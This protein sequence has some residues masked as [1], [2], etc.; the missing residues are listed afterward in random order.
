M[1]VDWSGVYP[2]LMTEFKDDESLDLHATATHIEACLSAGVDGFVILG[3][4]GENCSLTPEEKRAV[5][6]CAVETVSGRVPVIAGCAEYTPREAIAYLADCAKLGA[7]GAMVLPAMVYKTAPQETLAH[8]RTIARA[9]DLPIMVYN[10]PISYG[11]DVTPE[12]F[13]ELADEPALVAIKESSDDVRRLTDIVNLVGDRYVLFCG[14]DD[15][16]L[17]AVVLGAVGWVAGLVNAFPHETVELYRHVKAGRLDEA[18]ALYRWFMPLL[19]LDCL[20]KLVQYIKLANQM[21]G[22]GSQMVRAP[23]MIL[24]G[25]ERYRIEALIQTALDARPKLAAE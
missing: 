15:I 17:E 20:P 2:A 13:A 24:E 10:N 19:H 18:R 3:T 8:F 22:M 1:Q 9:S 14:V 25:E 5:I 11:T 21:T 7:D 12:M 23:R 16:A 4:L 6:G